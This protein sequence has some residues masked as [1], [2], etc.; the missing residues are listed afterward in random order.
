MR[1]NTDANATTRA[2]VT[3][4]ITTP[5]ITTPVITAAN[6][7]IATTAIGTA[8]ITTAPASAG[9]A[10]ISAAVNAIALEDLA[11]RA[12][13]IDEHI[14]RRAYTITENVSSTNNVAARDM[15]LLQR[16]WITFMQDIYAACSKEFWD[17]FLPIHTFPVNVIDTVLRVTKSTFLKRRTQQWTRYPSSR[18]ALLKK[19]NHAQDFWR[20]V[21]H[22]S[23]IDV[24]RV[25]R[26][27]LASGT[28][29]VVFEFVDPVWAWLT[30]AQDMNPLDLHWKPAAQNAVT[31]RYGGGVQYGDCFR[32]ACASCLP[33]GYPMCMGLHWDGTSGGGI[34]STPI[35]VGVM[36][37]N[38]CGA[39]TQCCIGYMPVVPDQARAEF[40]KTEDAT[41]LKWYIRQECFRAIARVLELAARRGVMCTLHN[42]L[43]SAVDRLLFP[44]LTAMNFDQPEAQ[45]FFGKNI[46][47]TLIIIS[48]NVN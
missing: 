17:V 43:N 22:R 1:R 11:R 20:K 29:S 24:S 40:A 35:C 13:D 16:E 23:E 7:A 46:A 4:T 3:A 14:F 38:S 48:I 19:L 30:V 45:L 6:A 34:S 18:R 10:T 27:P 39:D 21:L 2:I 9:A 42:R 41:K 5:V 26:V 28:Q 37:T 33:H 8:S 25:T 31:P 47:L 36:N 32:E 15:R 44:R 12:P